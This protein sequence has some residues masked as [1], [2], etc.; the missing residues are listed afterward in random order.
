MTRTPKLDLPLIAPAQAQKHITH[1]EALKA[2]DSI[3]HVSVSSRSLLEPPT[4]PENAASYLLPAGS[5]GLW[6]NQ[7]G[8]LAVVESGHWSFF[9]PKSGWV[10]WVEDEAQALISDGSLWHGLVNEG[11]DTFSPIMGVNTMAD[12]T[13]RLSVKS[14]AVL[15]SH[16]DAT[17]GSGD[18]RLIL[19][20][21]VANDTASIVYQSN[22]SGRAECGLSGDDRLQIKV[23]TDGADWKTALSVDPISGV[24]D[25]PH[26]RS[27]EPPMNLLKDSG[28]FCGS[29]DPQSVSAPNFGAPS[30]LAPYNGAMFEPGPAF[31]HNNTT[32]GGSV[33]ELDAKVD[34]FI[35][36]MK[37]AS[38]RR[39]GVEFYILK[40]TAGI[41]T[42]GALVSGD[43]NYYLS[44]TNLSVPIP[45]R[46]SVNYHILVESGAV[47]IGRS[48]DRYIDG[49]LSEDLAVSITS[50]NGWTQITQLIDSPPETFNGYQPNLM[51]VYGSPG[52][53]FYLAAPVI[54]PG[55]IETKPGLLHGI[56][57]SLDA[58]R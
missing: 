52:S 8:K 4:D 39:Y 1:N 34:G 40:V 32:Y 10:I 12:E 46:L 44:L 43:T 15:L 17:P 49:T 36:R 11:R 29:P 48:G 47:A 53:V 26:T 51:R 24:V 56:V 38:T 13:N 57:P 22:W 31:I 5:Q 20:K 2:L 33:G 14:D 54:M 19:N 45:P 21:A 23:S 37:S 41:G 58:W 25:M 6:Q 42:V 7:D 3:L 28:R 35:S 30:Y 9:T 16:D 55:H 27:F 18:M 50:S